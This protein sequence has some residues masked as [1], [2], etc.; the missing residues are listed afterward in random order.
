MKDVDKRII[1]IL[2]PIITNMNFPSVYEAPKA[3]AV[4]ADKV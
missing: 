3:D 2:P 4:L 1:C